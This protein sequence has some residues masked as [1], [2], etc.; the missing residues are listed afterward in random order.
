MSHL[1]TLEGVRKEYADIAAVN[2]VDLTVDSG[3]FVVLL[4]PSGSGK[5][6]LLSMLGGFITPTAGRI[7]IDGADMTG[8]SPAH[9]P[10]ATVFQDY[11]LFPHMNVTNNVGF[12]LTMHGIR[13][14]E[15]KRRIDETLALVGLEEF[16]TRSIHQLSGGQRQRVA[17]ARAIAVQPTVL[18]LDEPLGA[19]DLALRRQMQ[20]ELVHIQKEVGMT[21]IHVTHDQDE[22]MSIADRIVIMNHGAIED[23]GP[24]RRVYLQPGSLFA[25]TF[26]GESNLIPGTVGRVDGSRATVAT[27]FGEWVVRADGEAGRKVWLALRPE[28]LGIGGADSDQS[29]SLGTANITEAVFQGSHLKV[30]ATSASAE[31]GELKLRLP[32]ATTLAVGEEIRIYANPGEVVT[33]D[34]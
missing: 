32:P 29:L 19:L 11:A 16:G 34:H 1:V 22:A 18:L 26:M 28:Q 12:G 30:L 2:S 23:I 13:G 14:P 6:T 15:R 8:V 33:L 24:P 20:E 27:P 5:T 25:A 9:R 31:V 17:L 4:G 7:L 21:F 10:T 3:E